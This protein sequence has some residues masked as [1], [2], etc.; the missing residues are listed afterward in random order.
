MRRWS[1]RDQDQE[2]G[3]EGRNC[4]FKGRS[5]KDEQMCMID[6]DAGERRRSLMPPLLAVS[7]H[8]STSFKV[9]QKLD[10]RRSLQELGITSIFSSEADLSAMT[11]TRHVTIAT[12]P[13]C[14]RPA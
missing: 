6:A 1:S 5:A 12:D 11:G 7:H 8:S 10:L 13:I 3:L 2:P 4:P 14:S 9:E